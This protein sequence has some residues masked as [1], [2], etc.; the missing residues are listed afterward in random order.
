MNGPAV[1]ERLDVGALSAPVR[2]I[3]FVVALLLVTAVGFVVGRLL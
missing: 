3:G 1:N 2:L